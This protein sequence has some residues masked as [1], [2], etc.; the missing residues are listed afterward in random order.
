MTLVKLIWNMDLFKIVFG[1][2][3]FE[4]ENRFMTKFFVF[5]FLTWPSFLPPGCNKNLKVVFVTD[6]FH[7]NFI[8]TVWSLV[9]LSLSIS[10][11]TEKSFF[12]FTENPLFSRPQWPKLYLSHKDPFSL[13][14]T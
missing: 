13:I 9:S 1:K 6:D 11:V 14:L 4:S 3:D 7:K 8:L 12:I 2:D 5:N 10:L